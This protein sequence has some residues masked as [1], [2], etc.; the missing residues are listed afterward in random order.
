MK[1]TKKLKLNLK[2]TLKLYNESIND[3]KVFPSGNIISIS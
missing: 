3:I 1:R 2:M